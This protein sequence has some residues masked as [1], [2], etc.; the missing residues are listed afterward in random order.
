MNR[1]TDIEILE[2]LQ[3]ALEDGNH[4]KLFLIA[5]VIERRARF[6]KLAEDILKNNAVPTKHE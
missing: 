1:Q 5:D 4:Y 3:R 2:V 6:E